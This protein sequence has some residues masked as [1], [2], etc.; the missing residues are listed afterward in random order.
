MPGLRL[1]QK[2]AVRVGGGANPRLALYVGIRVKE[3]H[4]AAGSVA[5]ALAA[6]QALR[7][8]VETQIEVESLDRLREALAHGATS[9]LL[10]NF[11]LARM[12]QA[13]AINH[14]AGSQALLE[15]SGSVQMAQL[16][17]IAATG[18]NRIHLDRPSYQGREGR[19]L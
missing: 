2:Y 7:S 18:V 4:I 9:V 6:A 11:D 14:R 12:R 5:A 13:V 17:N 15:V 8:G 10:D 19:G 3:N 1:T 16:R